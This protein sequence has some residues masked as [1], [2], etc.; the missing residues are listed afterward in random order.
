V[1]TISR[2][3]GI[4]IRMYVREH[5]PPHFHAIYGNEEASIEIE[6]LQ[7]LEGRLS[8]RAMALVVEW[9]FQ[10]RDELRDNWWRAERHEPL[11]AI[12]PLE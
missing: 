3:F 4:A 6:R 1:P 12:E 7:V 11:L 5:G 8:R 9:A 2:F 10:H